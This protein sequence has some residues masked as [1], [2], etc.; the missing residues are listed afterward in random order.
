MN[1]VSTRYGKMNIID[2]DQIVSRS[3]SMY[4]EWASDEL[5]LLAKIIKPAST[6]LDIGSFIGTHTLAFAQ[7]VGATGRVYAFEPRIEIFEV[8]TANIQLNQ[9]NQVTPMN[10]GLADR[11]HSITLNKVDL[12][13]QNNFGGLELKQPLISDV[14]TYPAQ[15]KTLDGLQLTAVDFIKIDVEGM[16]ALVLAGGIETIDTHRPVIFCEC[17]AL[18]AGNDLLRFFEG[19][20][21][22]IY[23]YLSASFQADN[24]NAAQEDFLE[25]GKELSLLML[26][27]EKA[28]DTLAA[29]QD[30]PLMARHD[31]W[32]LVLMLLN[33]PQYIHDVLTQTSPYTYLGSDFPSTAT[34][35][36][37]AAQRDLAVHIEQN[38]ILAAKLAELEHAFAYAERL[39]VESLEEIQ[40]LD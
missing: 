1:V 37:S 31:V 19:R 29:L 30:Y 12:L 4:G 17:N 7:F 34:A 28:A 26:P 9:L 39:S 20:D 11:A 25:G 38:R 22:Q 13:H 3:L 23:G 24:F 14:E 40:A 5:N 27:K 35:A 32:D 15:I 21:Y 6:V 18:A 10:I 2:T 36:L 16:E 33:R 8:L